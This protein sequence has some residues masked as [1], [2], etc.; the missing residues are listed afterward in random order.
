MTTFKE[1][2]QKAMEKDGWICT[3]Q[4]G[5]TDFIC[6]RG[7]YTIAVRAK[8]HGRI[9]N[10]EWKCLCKYGKQNNRHVLYV[11]QNSERCLSFV[12]VYPEFKAKKV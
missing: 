11:H 10:D 6:T 5:I 8:K 9:Y 1:T 7:A 4:K 2:V 12:R 3:M